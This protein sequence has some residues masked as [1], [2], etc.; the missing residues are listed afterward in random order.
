[1]KVIF[2]DVDGVLN[3]RTTYA[4]DGFFGIDA[5]MSLLVNRICERT[6]AQIVISSSWRLDKGSLKQIEEKVFPKFIDI[7]PDRRGLTSRGTEI[8]TWLDEHPFWKCEKTCCLRPNVIGHKIKRYAII[9]DNNDMLE[10]QMPNFFKT[11]WEFGLT[12]EIAERI[13]AHLI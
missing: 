9:D 4:R 3:C 8:K 11:S 5:Y 12:D 10:E 13:I 6:D 7:T 2:L 1:M